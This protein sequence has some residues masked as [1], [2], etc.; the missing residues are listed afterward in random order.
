[1]QRGFFNKV[2]EPRPEPQPLPKEPCSICQENFTS[3]RNIVKCKNNHSTHV[4]CISKSF[5]AECPMCRDPLDL[6]VDV[7]KKIEENSKKVHQE[8]EED[9]RQELLNETSNTFGELINSLTELT[10][11]ARNTRQSQVIMDSLKD[12]PP[13]M[14]RKMYMDR[15]EKWSNDK[16]L[17]FLS[18]DIAAEL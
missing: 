10:N 2:Q 6:E 8:W 5:K 3:F 15:I 16:V 4:S 1:M 12:L 17:A 9:E 14:I 11:F 7:L 18:S 13:E